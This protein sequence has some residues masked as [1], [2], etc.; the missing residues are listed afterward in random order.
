MQGGGKARHVLVLHRALM[1]HDILRCLAEGRED[2]EISSA[3][4]IEQAEA[5]LAAG[6]KFDCILVDPTDGSAPGLGLLAR[7]AIAAGTIPVI[8]LQLRPSQGLRIIAAGFGISAI[9]DAAAPA[10]T[11][12]NWFDLLTDRRN[13]LQN[14]DALA[15]EKTG[16]RRRQ[17]L[18]CGL[19]AAGLPNSDIASRIGTSVATIKVEV[20][21]LLRLTGTTNR[22]QLALWLETQARALS[23]SEA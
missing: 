3:G 15:A 19:V 12:F 16:L 13:G 2:L 22:V 9:V 21:K 1:F 17:W 10:S 8:G 11:I 23:E 6:R 14:T 5:M 20:H 7:L 18:I 4:S